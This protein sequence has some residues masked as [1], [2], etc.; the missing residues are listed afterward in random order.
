MGKKQLINLSIA[1]N[2]IYFW[3]TLYILFVRAA[4]EYCIYR[5]SIDFVRVSKVNVDFG[6]IF[7]INY[8]PPNHFLPISV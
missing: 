8:L 4:G 2:N 1:I 7:L 6:L 3:T 5:W